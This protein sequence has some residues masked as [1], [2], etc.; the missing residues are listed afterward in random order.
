ML[1]YVYVLQ[2][3]LWYSWKYIATECIL[4]PGVYYHLVCITAECAIY[5]Y[6]SIYYT[7]NFSLAS[8]I[9][10][11]A[12]KTGSIQREIWVCYEI[13]GWNQGLVSN[14]QFPRTFFHLPFFH[15]N[16]NGFMSQHCC[17]FYHPIITLLQKKR[18][19]DWKNKRLREVCSYSAITVNLHKALLLSLEQ[20]LLY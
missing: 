11:P 10:L 14:H 3:S 19:G 9:P 4:L 18:E 1:H 8:L 2:Q 7:S 17:C 12:A 20:F 16:A 5:R 13:K 6:Y 15:P